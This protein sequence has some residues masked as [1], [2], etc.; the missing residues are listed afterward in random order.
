MVIT[1]YIANE[2]GMPICDD[3][4]IQMDNERA[5]RALKKGPMDTKNIY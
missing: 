4:S 5:L 2:C 1:M 3:D